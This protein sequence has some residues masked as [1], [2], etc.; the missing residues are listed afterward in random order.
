ML[1]YYVSKYND[2]SMIQSLAIDI[3]TWSHLQSPDVCRGIIYEFSGEI[4]TI[5][6]TKPYHT[7]LCTQL[8]ICDNIGIVSSKYNMIH[9]LSRNDHS[10]SIYKKHLKNSQKYKVHNKIYG[11][12]GT[13]IQLSDIHYDPFYIIG[14]D[15]I[16][17][18]PLCCRSGNGSHGG[19][20]GYYGSLG[21]DTNTNLMI[22]A[23]KAIKK[24]IANPD[25]IIWTGDAPAHDIWAQSWD[26]MDNAS[27]EISAFIRSYY[28]ESRFIFSIGNHENYPSDQDYGPGKNTRLIQSLLTAW[29]DWMKAEE[30]AT[31]TFAGYYS[32]TMLSPINNSTLRII[33]LN[34]DFSFF[35]NLWISLYNI[36]DDIGRQWQWLNETLA[37]SMRN[38]ESVWIIS[39]SSFGDNS[40]LDERSNQFYSTIEP[41]M[42]NIKAQFH[43]HTHFDSFRL[44]KGNEKVKGHVEYISPAMSPFS[45]NYPSFR[46][47][48]FDLETFEIVDYDQYVFNLSSDNPQWKLSYQAS[49][50]Y[51]MTSLSFDSWNLLKEEIINYPE[52]MHRFCYNYFSGN[53]DP[54]CSNKD[55]LQDIKCQVSTNSYQDFNH[56]I[57]SDI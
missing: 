50:E 29:Q 35:T 44:V 34:S 23:F 2:T 20:A 6:K 42:S 18:N 40:V 5:L 4:I 11:N 21:C 16:C 24:I 13:M 56:C 45:H 31:F 30:I 17:E 32:S 53:G 22:S 26:R 51:N 47:Y 15:I 7:E 46:L 57:L 41:Y 54:F 1:S 49:N 37:D 28:P 38:N 33:S 55:I 8:R 12:I 19:L 52:M 10:L 48:Y 9:S 36:T 25:I 43:G 27:L 14:S 39:H 3:C